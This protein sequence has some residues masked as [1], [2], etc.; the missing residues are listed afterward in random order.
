MIEPI[1]PNM[2]ASEIISLI[3]LIGIG[4]LLKSLFD[5]FIGSRRAKSEKKQEFKEVRY[6]AIILLCHAYINYDSEEMHLI[7][8]R[9]DIKSREALYNELKAE[10]TNMVLYASDKVI[11]S[12][13]RFLESSGKTTFN[14]MV[15]AMRKDLYGIRTR[16]KMEN[17][18]L[19]DK[20]ATSL[21]K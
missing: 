9:P 20:E 18:N 3:G 11:L 5:L 1:P 12:M 17:L 19:T 4:G 14:E 21:G 10:W 6:K 16:L 2:T 13:K 7:I 8:Q 15:L